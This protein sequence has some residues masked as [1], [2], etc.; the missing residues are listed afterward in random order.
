MKLER[1]QNKLDQETETRLNLE[2]RLEEKVREYELQSHAQA[3]YTTEQPR[4]DEE[5]ETK[6][7]V[8]EPMHLKRRN[9]VKHERFRNLFKKDGDS[10]ED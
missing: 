9:T 1:V 2:E 6:Q 10:L 3:G 8:M 5:E 4:T 7:V